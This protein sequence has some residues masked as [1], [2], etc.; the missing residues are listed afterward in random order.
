[1]RPRGT[2]R[3]R[4]RRGEG[5]AA[6]LCACMGGRR[7]YS[8]KLR[9]L[10]GDE[11]AP[12]R[13]R[14]GEVRRRRRDAEEAACARTSEGRARARAGRYHEEATHAANVY[15]ERVCCRSKDGKVEEHPL[16]PVRPP[17]GARSPRCQVKPGRPEPSRRARPGRARPLRPRA[18]LL[19]FNA[20]ARNTAAI[21]VEVTARW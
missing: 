5:D 12:A 6:C 17:L 9:G 7:A 16:E 15:T 4:R 21:R 2:T 19:Y 3:R 10:G 14:E 11:V 8:R 1:M 18:S 13:G 20:R